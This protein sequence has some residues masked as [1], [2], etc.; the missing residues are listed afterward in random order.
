METTD[1]EKYGLWWRFTDTRPYNELS[2]MHRIAVVDAVDRD[3]NRM[4]FTSDAVTYRGRSYPVPVFEVYGYLRDGAYTDLTIRSVHREY[5][6]DGLW[7]SMPETIKSAISDPI[8]LTQDQRGTKL[9][10]SAELTGHNDGHRAAREAATH[11]YR[12]S[13]LYSREAWETFA[14]DA[15]QAYLDALLEHYSR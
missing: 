7:R 12:L 8:G 9:Q 2:G 3:G 6:P 4:P 1:F 10:V 13:E 11:P 14:K 15:A 5:W